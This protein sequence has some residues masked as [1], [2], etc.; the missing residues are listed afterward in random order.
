[1]RIK[2]IADDSGVFVIEL[3]TDEL[4]SLKE[5][6]M[7]PDQSYERTLYHLIA[8]ILLTEPDR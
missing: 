4:Q 5:R 2:Q 6:K 3:T 7:H 8:S 1:M